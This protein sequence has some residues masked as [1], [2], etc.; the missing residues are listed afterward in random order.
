VPVA[1][2]QKS[3]LFYV[4]IFQY[5]TFS[6]KAID[7]KSAC[8]IKLVLPYNRELTTVLINTSISY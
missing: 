6:V 5:E 2:M 7:F 8:T 4:F 3:F 1:K